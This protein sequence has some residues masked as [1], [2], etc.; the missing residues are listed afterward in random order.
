MGTKWKSSIALVAWVLLIT[1]GL[2]GV[3]WGVTDAN[4]Y[5]KKNYFH[6]EEFEAELDQFINYLSFFELSEVTKDDI[7]RKLTV[8]ASEIEEHRTRYGDLPEQ[9]ASIQGQYES[10][11]QEAQYTKNDAVAKALITERDKKIEDISNNF[12]SDEYVRE[13][14]LKEKEQAIENYYNDQENNRA[15]FLRYKAAFKYYLKNTETEDVYTNL[16]I[17]ED[18]SMET[19]KDE[20]M[21]KSDML[22]IR[23]YPSEGTDYLSTE[24]RNSFFDYENEFAMPS[25][26]QDA[27]LFEG[28]IAIPKWS[29]TSSASVLAGYHTYHNNQQVFFIY[30]L[31]GLAAL[32]ISLYLYKRISKAPFVT[33]M[34]LVRPYYNRIPIDVRTMLLGFTGFITLLVLANSNYI[35]YDLNYYV[36]DDIISGL[37]VQALFV[38]LTLM[39]GILL[40]ERFKDSPRLQEDWKRSFLPRGYKAVKEAF[41]NRKTGTQT[42]LLLAF[43]FVSG[44][45]VT[46]SVIQPAV[47]VVTIPVMIFIG[48]PIVFIIFKRTGYFNKIAS[49]TSELAR[50]QYPQDL[51]VKGRSALA[52]LAGNINTLKTG[53]KISQKEQAK[54]ERL[55]TELISNVSHDL[56]TPLTSIIT[57]TE[58]LKTPDL[59]EEDRNSY[60]QIIDRKSKRLK[61]LIDDL[62]EASKMASGSVDLI[63][64][65]VDIV[66]L[67]QQALAEHNETI[68]ES[69]LQFRVTNPDKPVY[70]I[71][72]GQKL[73]RM[74]DNLIGNI[75]KYSLENTRVYISLKAEKDQAI[76]AFKNVAKYEIG[77]NTDELFERFKRGDTSRHT[78]GSG[79][80]L[81][82]AKS[83]ADLHGGSLDIEVDADLF[84]VIVTLE[85]VEA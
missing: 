48:M 15:E 34:E 32:L 9:I 10:R 56:R 26:K 81:A 70:A 63:K 17:S 78:E 6:T 57:Y 31:T 2:S 51:P 67:L 54:S 11:I 27:R 14:V 28:V 39:Q 77:E 72:D 61:V 44:V 55:K 21:T 36:I 29:V 5:L 84:K 37:F 12:S 22:F 45:G 76:I 46:V 19:V 40:T 60:I 71:V 23:S 58:L 50:G 3:V 79:L 85:I 65:R 41:V 80:G 18:E 75:L 24:G 8:T 43:V 35:F 30:T 66:Q 53:V 13:K 74:F 59:P 20:V 47:F 82:I 69:T 7:K 4:R 64:E 62:F 16:N 1:F 33:A 38:L 83:I 73:W 42:F 49:T 52:E 68:K 25:V